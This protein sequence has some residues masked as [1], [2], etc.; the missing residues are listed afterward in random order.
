LPRAVQARKF[1]IPHDSEIPPLDSPPASFVAIFGV[2][3]R[4]GLLSF[5]GGLSGWIFREVVTLRHWIDEDEFFSGLA[6]SQI[7]PGANVTNLSVYIGNK[8]KGPLGALT[9]LTALLAG[10]FFAVI[11]LASIYSVLRAMPFVDAALD[12]V[13]AAAIGLLLVVTLKGARR[14][15]QRI[16]ALAAFAITFIAVGLLHFSLL[17]VVVIVGPLSVAAAWWRGRVQDNANG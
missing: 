14:A 13:T 5:G 1:R 4:I 16:E 8:L 3:F 7:L 2:F 15:A 6:V 17:P 10:P 11:F 9:A 12:G